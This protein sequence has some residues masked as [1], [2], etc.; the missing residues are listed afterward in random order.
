V[1]IVRRQQT[2]R[3][4][5]SSASGTA[6]VANKSSKRTG[7]FPWNIACTSGAATIRRR[8]AIK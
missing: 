6:T 1:P 7:R 3:Q 5:S 2:P 4:A 8:P